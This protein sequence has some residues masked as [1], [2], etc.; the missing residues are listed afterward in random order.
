MQMRNIHRILSILVTVFTVY[1]GVTGTL[2]E[3]IDFRT[4][5]THAPAIDPD[6]MAMREDFA[7]P[8]SFRV[9]GVADH[10]APLLPHGAD[11]PSMVQTVT[12]AARHQFVSAPFKFVELRMDG[13]RPVGHVRIEQ[14]EFRF[15]AQSGAFLGKAPE[16]RN[17]DMPPKSWRN[18]FKHLHRMTTFGNWALWINIMVSVALAVLIVTGVVIYWRVYAVRRRIKRS[19]PFWT[20]GGTL[21]HLHRSISI[22]A[23]LFITV[24]SLSGAWLAVESL[25]FSLYLEHTPGVFAVDPSAPLDDHALPSMAR[26][27]LAAYQR[28]APGQGLR[29][30][31]LRHFG[32]WRQGVV[33]T[34][35]DEARQLVFDTA[36]GRALRLTEAGYPETGFPFGWQAHQWAKSVHRGDFFGVTGRFTSFL[37]GLAMIYL[38]VSGV[39]M[40]WTMWQK[41][42]ASGRPAFFWKG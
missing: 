21:R 34:P 41:R 25:M 7:G 3:M 14:G 20:A 31:R 5:A 27:T 10:N 4:L 38:S 33:I 17:E 28:V 37:S 23:G 11:L 1:L 35:G 32:G 42:R 18:N 40:Y 2:I 12:H 9:L 30:I 15:D 39:A 16:P 6:R 29:V 36:T 26:A 19:N 13:A 24:V 22:A 8:P